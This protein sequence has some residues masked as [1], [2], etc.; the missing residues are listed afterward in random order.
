MGTNQ[1]QFE[2]VNHLLHAVEERIASLMLDLQ[3]LD[4]SKDADA[5]H[6]LEEQ[7]RALTDQQRMLSKRWRELT[8]GYSDNA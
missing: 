8:A 6:A 1:L 4:E 7:I 5:Y 2:E 3:K